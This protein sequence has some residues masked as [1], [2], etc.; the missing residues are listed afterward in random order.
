MDQEQSSRWLEA[1]NQEKR[2]RNRWQQTYLTSDELAE[3][4]DAE[5]SVMSQSIA[6]RANRRIT[7]QEAMEMRC[8]GASKLRHSPAARK[9]FCWARRAPPPPCRRLA[10]VPLAEDQDPARPSVSAYAQRR[11]QVAAQARSSPP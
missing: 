6:N 8:G 1:L 7:G 5:A 9:L 11:A 10:N 4:R 2:S 3:L